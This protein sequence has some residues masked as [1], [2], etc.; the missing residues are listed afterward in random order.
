MEDAKGQRRGQRERKKELKIHNKYILK[1]QMKMIYKYNFYKQ[2][3]I[4]TRSMVLSET[5]E[6]GMRTR[7]LK[8]QR[9]IRFIY[10]LPIAI[11]FF[12]NIYASKLLIEERRNEE[13]N[14]IELNYK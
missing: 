7:K 9:R 13:E 8:R 1:I 12:S 3:E 5:R 4:E 2:R 11:I 10:G 6:V 14:D